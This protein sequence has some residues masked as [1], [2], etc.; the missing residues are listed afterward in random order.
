MS[1]RIARGSAAVVAAALALG[2]GA[3]GKSDADS[4]GGGGSGGNSLKTG[5]GVTDTTITLGVLTDLSGVFA[6]LAKPLTAA[7]ELYWEKQNAAG[8]ACDRKVELVIKDHGYDPQKAVSLYRDIS[9]R[10]AGLQQLL[11]SPVA[12]ALLPA[13]DRDDMYAGLAAWPSSLLSNDNVQIT[14]TTYDLEIVNG[15]DFLLEKGLIKT[16]DKLG[17]VYFEGD[18]GENALQGSEYAAE[19][20]NLSIVKQ[21]IKPTETD[22]SAQISV[23]KRQGVRAILVSAAPGQ[24][25]S[26]AGVAK[27][28]GLNVPILANGPGFAPQLLKTPAAAALRRNLYVVSSVAPLTLDEPGVAPV[29]AAWKAEHAGEPAAAISVVF[30]WAMAKLMNEVLDKACENK[31]LSRAGLVTALHQLDGIDTGGL[32]AAP[33]TYTKLGE[34]PARAVYV[35]QPKA[36]PEDGGLEVVSDGAF[37]S[38]AAKGYS[39]SS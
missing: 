38:D 37:E 3:C 31:D 33:L 4:A 22:M 8:G 7:Q 16:G 17:H 9:P 21:K 34:P 27:G 14:G 15:I 28:A 19:Q 36:A 18:Y 1:T 20:H 23:F 10:V 35:A 29:V 13:M 24:T 39:P 32:I 26:A 12:A 25:A 30:G 6:A 2:V 5:P 11:G